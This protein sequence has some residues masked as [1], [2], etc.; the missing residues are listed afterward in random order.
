M[1]NSGVYFIKNL[2]NKKIYIGS[3]KDVPQRIDYHKR[4]L[5]KDKHENEYLQNAW[6]KYG[7][8]NFQFI[9]RISCDPKYRLELE[10]RLIDFY[11]CYKRDIG[12]NLEKCVYKT[13][14]REETKRKISQGLKEYYKNN[15]HPTTNKSVSQELRDH[16][17]EINTGEKHPQYG[18]KRDER[19]KE[20]ISNALEGRK[21]P[22]LSGEDHPMYGKSHSKEAIKKMREAHDKRGEEMS[23]SKL[24]KRDVKQIKKRIKGNETYKEIADDYSV[25]ESNIAEIARGS[26]WTHVEV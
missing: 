18:T 26:T 13:E 25:S 8:E 11:E 24:K 14:V 12:Y 9:F 17:S 16:L 15:E 22:N 7:S 2:V 10:Q 1:L 20:K 6:N 19:T 4:K 21:R 3:S 23:C 5:D